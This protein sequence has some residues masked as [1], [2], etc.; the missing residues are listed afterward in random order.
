LRPLIALFFHKAHARADLKAVKAGLPDAVSVKIDLATVGA[1][2]E[3][4]AIL[5][6]KF[7]HDARRLFLM[8]LYLAAHL[9]DLIL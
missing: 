4:V 7:R 2:Q 8:D 6:P 9:A 5:R 3:A 1:F